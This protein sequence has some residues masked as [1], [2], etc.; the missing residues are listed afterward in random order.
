MLLHP[1]ADRRESAALP[2]L[3]NSVPLGST[4]RAVTPEA[5]T[6]VT[7][8]A[9]SNRTS[10]LYVNGSPVIVLPLAE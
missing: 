5:Y 3:R 6:C 10:R 9:E 7:S 1:F 2:A 8:P 4:I